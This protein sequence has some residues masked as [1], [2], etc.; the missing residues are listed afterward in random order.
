MAFQTFRRSLPLIAV[1]LLGACAKK[2]EEPM[3]VAPPPPSVLLVQ[4]TEMS[5]HFKAVDGHLELGGTFY[6]YADVD[7]DALEVAKPAQEF[8]KKMAET[9]PKLSM[10]AKQD[11]KEFMTTLGIDDIKAVGMSSVR[12]SSGYY[13]NRTFIYTPN[14]RHGLLAVFGG[15][16]GPFVNE[17]LAPADVDYY[18]EFDVN[19]KAIY[20]TIEAVIQKVNGP[21]AATDFRSK[22]KKIG[23][24]ANFSLLDLINGLNTKVT[25][26]M[27]FDDKRTL[28]LGP[29][30]Q[31]TVPA[32]DSLFEVDGVGT[33]IANAIKDEVSKGTFVVT[34]SGDLTLYTSKIPS[35]I[36]GL[37]TV[38]GF[39]KDTLYVASSTD[40]LKESLARTSGLDAN[41]AFTAGLAP[42]GKE[43][44]GVTWISPHY[45]SRLKD[46]GDMNAHASPQLHTFLEAYSRNLPVISQ[47]LISL[48]TNLPEGILMRST[49]NRSLKADVALLMIYNPV[50]IGLVAAAAI[51]A[52]QKARYAQRPAASTYQ[53]SYN[54]NSGNLSFPSTGAFGQFSPSM[55]LGGTTAPTSVP[56]PPPPDM[57]STAKQYEAVRHNLVLISQDAEYYY[58]ARGVTSVAYDDLYGFGKVKGGFVSVAGEDYHSLILRKGLILFLHMPD[59][60]I[61]NYSPPDRANALHATEAQ[62]KIIREHLI[63]LHDAMEVHIKTHSPQFVYYS[64]LSNGRYYQPFFPVIGEDYSTI[65]FIP[66]EPLKLILPDGSVI[67]YP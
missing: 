36:P 43:G 28:D 53:K 31:L 46:L 64:D 6:G 65:S 56:M 48:R 14:G 39:R 38:I 10:F 9:Q 51:P 29:P 54:L 55:S 33:V 7:G 17:K 19:L 20:D 45:M 13:R 21:D 23:A 26:F 34:T 58:A 3:V 42:L 27:R 18:T 4:A 62:K 30:T 60:H 61:V 15:N 47:P 1:L 32:F 25:F 22:V 37:E 8:V 2:A 57:M 24:A 63:T 16:P 67:T 59:G 40:F 50:T 5:P 49:W 52:F 41:P 12:E 35:K 44:N 66:W 11:F